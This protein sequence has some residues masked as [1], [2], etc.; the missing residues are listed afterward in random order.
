MYP[1]HYLIAV[2]FLHVGSMKMAERNPRSSGLGVC[3]MAPTSP[4]KD[5]HFTLAS[6]PMKRLAMAFLA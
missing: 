3:G 1:N 6:L 5:H 2:S 4:S